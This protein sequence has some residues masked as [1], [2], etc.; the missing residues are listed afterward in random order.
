[1]VTKLGFKFRSQSD[2]HAVY[3]H[4]D[5]RKTTVSV[6]PQDTIGIGLL[7]KIVKKDLEISKEDFIKL[8]KK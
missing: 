4:R 8:L 6:H 3:I 5:G 2:S 1:M 7:T